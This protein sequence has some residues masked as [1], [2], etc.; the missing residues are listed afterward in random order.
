MRKIQTLLLIFLI[1]LLS[2]KSDKKYSDYNEADFYE[3]QGIINQAILTSDPFD[4]TT[5]K[6]ISFTYFLDRPNPKKGV[7]NNL[8]MFEAQNGY[9]LIVL[10]HKDDENISFYGRV[11][12]LENLNEKEKAYL[13]NHFQNEM[14]K[15]KKRTPDYI[16]EAL[17]NDT[18]N[19]NQI[20]I[21]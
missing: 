8:E 21:K 11:G 18:I 15:L 9:P 14:D 20:D 5:E 1:G 16:Y 13:T 3:V 2:C 12:V 7:E 17:I 4:S 10:V 19:E 6:N